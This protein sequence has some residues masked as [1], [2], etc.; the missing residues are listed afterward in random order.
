MRR[1]AK[2]KPG[3]ILARIVERYERSGWPPEFRLL[4]A[5]SDLIEAVA[6]EESER[7]ER[8]R[9]HIAEHWGFRIDPPEVW[10]PRTEQV[11]R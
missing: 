6:S 5:F 11:H 7:V 8:L 2:E 1:T 9:D 4:Y 3:D 10:P